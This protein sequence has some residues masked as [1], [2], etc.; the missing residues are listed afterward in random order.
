[1]ATA[2][3]EVQAYNTLLQAIESS[4]PTGPTAQPPHTQIAWPLLSANFTVVQL[5]LGTA[6]IDWLNFKGQQALTCYIRA[7]NDDTLSQNYWAILQR[8]WEIVG[9][10]EALFVNWQQWF[11]TNGWTLSFGDHDYLD[12]VII[13]T[14][15]GDDIQQQG[16]YNTVTLKGYYTWHMT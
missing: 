8:R 1:M 12:N 10:M 15:E 14:I 4:L 3:R 7:Q 6:T 11:L 13:S 9:A 5:E 2:G 16:S